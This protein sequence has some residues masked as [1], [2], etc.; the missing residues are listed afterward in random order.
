LI[1][2]LGTGC[3]KEIVHASGL[4]LIA[5]EPALLEVQRHPRDNS[6]NPLQPAVA[7]GLIEV[8]RLSDSGLAAFVELAG[9]G[10]LGDGEAATIAHAASAGLG[11]VLDDHKARRVCAERYDLSQ[12]S[13]AEFLRMGEQN[14]DDNLLREAVFGA[15]FYA[16]MRVFPGQ[17]DW[18]RSLIGTERARQCSS[19]RQIHGTAAQGSPE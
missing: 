18:V 3:L 19:L 5:C 10:D 7:A 13:S 15:L 11:V 6:P 9:D 17:E 8:A 2:L 4:R 1:N 12:L 14:L 16:R